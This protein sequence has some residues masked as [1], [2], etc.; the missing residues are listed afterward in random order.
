MPLPLF[1]DVTVLLGTSGAPNK[2]RCSG[3]SILKD[4]VS[5]DPLYSVGMYDSRCA[6]TVAQCG[7]DLFAY[8][9]AN[10][11]ELCAA[12]GS[13]CAREPHGNLVAQ[14][15]AH[16]MRFRGIIAAYDGDSPLLLQPA[17]L[18][19]SCMRSCRLGMGG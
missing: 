7:I 12:V 11:N 19:G 4:S 10:E 2:Y 14:Q 8:Y 3:Q 15:T 18:G 9:G 17:D 5:D 1:T 6:L 13:G 16:S